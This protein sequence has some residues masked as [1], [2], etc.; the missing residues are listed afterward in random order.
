MAYIA[1]T[2]VFG[3][4]PSAAKWNQ[5]TGNDASFNDGTGFAAG[6][7]GTQNASLAAGIACQFAYNQ[8]ATASTGT[9]TIPT[10]SSIPQI[11][12]GDQYMTQAIT[13]KAT[14]NILLIEA[15][16]VVSYSVASKDITMALFQ[17]STANALSATLLFSPA[18]TTVPLIMT[19]RYAM[20][21][22][23]TGST[24][25]RIRIG[26]ETAAGGTLSFNAAVGVSPIFGS[27]MPK[28]GMWI[29]EYKA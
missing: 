27:T 2:F 1:T 28:S 18:T 9:T 20:A 19:L 16:A 11:T 23:T 8:V 25:F 17:D 5:L 6:A 22:G 10:D 4:Q 3:E 21:A 13:P 29:T 12:E 24:T 14:T 26:A 15:Q 7:I